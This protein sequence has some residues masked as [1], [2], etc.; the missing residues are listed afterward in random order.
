MAWAVRLLRPGDIENVLEIQAAS[1]TPQ[2]LEDGDVFLAKIGD[3][4]DYCIGA[5]G[6]SGQLVAYVIAFPM[7]GTASIGLHEQPSDLSDLSG[8]ILYIHDMAVH[9]S[10]QGRGI[11]RVLLGEL[12][13]VGRGNGQRVIE[14]V[15]IESAVGYWSAHG[16]GETDDA[17]YDGYGPG[18]RKMRRGL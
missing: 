5:V 16:F 7:T 18:A 10:V 15:A 13:S 1:Y 4:P 2:L 11:G 9:P 8:P 6:A 3:A 12:E 14:L 17:V